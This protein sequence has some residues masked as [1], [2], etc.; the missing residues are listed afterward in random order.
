MAD[1]PRLVK[2]MLASLRHDFPA[3]EEDYGWELEVGRATRG[4]LR[5]RRRGATGLA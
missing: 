5:Q 2:P 1:M 4:G 3:D